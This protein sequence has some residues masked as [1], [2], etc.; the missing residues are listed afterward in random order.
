DIS[1][2]HTNTTMS[3]LSTGTRTTAHQV[4]RESLLL[5][6]LRRTGVAGSLGWMWRPIE[7]RRVGRARV[8]GVRR[9]RRADRAA[10][11]DAAAVLTR[12]SAR[13]MGPCS[14]WPWTLASCPR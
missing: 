13:A 12:R 3:R 11:G 14:F 2:Y 7:Q 10:G 5:E 9:V 6:L 8:A 1:S 4:Y